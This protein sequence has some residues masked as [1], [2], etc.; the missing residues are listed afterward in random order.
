MYA[1][2]V[3]IQADTRSAIEST[4]YCW[5]ALGNLTQRIDLAA[6]L[7]DTLF[8]DGMNRLTHVVTGDPGQGINLTKTVAY[9]ATGNITSRSDLG[10]YSY[11]PS[12][13]HVVT[14]ITGSF[15]AAYVYDADGNMTLG[16]GRRKVLGVRVDFQNSG[17]K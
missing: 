12:H 3:A 9:D 17:A 2:W 14:G 5:D 1:P 7:T 15:N 10:S 16:G 4:S 6:G 8:Y 11:D 13:V